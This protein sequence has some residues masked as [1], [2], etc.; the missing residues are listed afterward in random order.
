MHS[1]NK[2]GVI[3]VGGTIGSVFAGCCLSKDEKNF[4]KLVN[5][6]FG[7]SEENIFKVNSFEYKKENIIKEAANISV[8]YK[9]DILDSTAIVSFFNGIKCFVALVKSSDGSGL[10]PNNG[11]VKKYDPKKEFVNEF[12]SVF[13]LKNGCVVP[14]HICGYYTFVKKTSDTKP[15]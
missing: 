4:K 15:V 7:V 3:L 2:Y 11:K 5:E 9:D 13:N 1:M 6:C 12:F 8:K 10:V 14:D